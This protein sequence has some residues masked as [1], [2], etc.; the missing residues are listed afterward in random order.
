[1]TT[2]D[3]YEGDVR[4]VR[5]EARLAAI[6]VADLMLYLRLGD[7]GKA[8]TALRNAQTHLSLVADAMPKAYLSSAAD[9]D[10]RD[11]MGGQR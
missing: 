2:S 5:L 1:M 6:N 4:T 9:L 7:T 10:W 11:Q 3:P 8:Q